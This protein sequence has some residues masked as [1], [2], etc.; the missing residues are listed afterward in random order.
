MSRGNARQRI[1][2]DERDYGR[3]ME[4]LEATVDKFGFE[5]FSF[6]RMPNH[7]HSIKQPQ[8]SKED[9]ENKADLNWPHWAKPKDKQQTARQLDDMQDIDLFSDSTS[10]K[11]NRPK[12][13]I[14]LIKDANNLWRRYT[15]AMTIRM[16]NQRG[17][18]LDNT[19]TRKDTE[20]FS[21]QRIPENTC[22]IADIYCDDQ[23]LLGQIT[24]YLQQ[25]L[26]IGRGKA[27][28]KCKSYTATS[29]TAPEIANYDGKTTSLTIIASSDWII[30]GKNL[31]YLTALNKQTLGKAFDINLS[32]RVV[33]LGGENSQFLMEEYNEF[34]DFEFEKKDGFDRFVLLSSNLYLQFHR[35]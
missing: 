27:P 1:F 30:R 12:G 5:I 3:M 4:G 23:D 15:Q 24:Q 35:Y 29:I 20:L 33:Q 9:G 6:V 17:D 26:K 13:E 14:Y 10:E 25:P 32:N 19:L 21:E 2:R 31:G 16:R 28:V 8:V 7:I 22:F 34:K 11:T 18:P